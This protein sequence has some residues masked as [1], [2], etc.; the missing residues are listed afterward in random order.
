LAGAAV[1]AGAGVVLGAAV[2]FLCFFTLVAGLVVLGVEVEAA[3][4]CAI[5]VPIMRERPIKAEAKVF[6]VL[7]LLFFLDAVIRLPQ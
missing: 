2:C 1:A 7:V 3:G 4:V 5:T 6:I